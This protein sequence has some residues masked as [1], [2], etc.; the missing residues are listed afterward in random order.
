M[1][2]GDLPRTLNGRVLPTGWDPLM[3]R[4]PWLGEHHALKVP[5][6]GSAEAIHAVAMGGGD[7]RAWALTPYNSARL[8]RVTDMDGLPEILRR[9]SPVHLTDVPGI[10]VAA[11]CSGTR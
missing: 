7:G 6:H 4:A 2:P 8:P 5:H 9:V 11:D 3:E 10:Q 1:L